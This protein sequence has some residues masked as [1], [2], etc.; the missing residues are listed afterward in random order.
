M[1]VQR[2]G[3]DDPHQIGRYRIL[4]VLGAGGMGRVLLGAGAD[5]RLVAIKQVHGHLLGETEYRARFRREVTATTRVSGAFTAPVIDFDIDAPDPWLASAFV[6]GVPLDQV[7]SEWGPLPV[8]ALRMLAAGLA[9]AL[10]AV[11]RAG[12]VHRDL[13]PA[14]VLLAADGPRVIDFGIAQLAENPGGLTE[15]GSAL[16]SPAFMSPEQALSERVSSASDVFSL[17]V[18]L[19][20]AATGT[21]PFAAQ[22]MAYTLFNIVH[23][24]PDLSRVPP[25]FRELL[26]AC[27]D[28]DPAAR[29]T[30]AQILR[31]LGR[32]ESFGRP[33]PE[34]IHQEIDRRASKLTVLTADPEGTSVLPGARRNPATRTAMAGAPSAHRRGRSRILVTA[35]VALLV[36]A[37]TAGAAWWRW[38]GE[39]ATDPA[40][41][42]L[43]ELR[44]TDACGWLRAALGS[45][46]P[47]NLVPAWSPDV[48]TWQFQTEPD[49]SCRAVGGRD[50]TLSFQPGGY[51]DALTRTGTTLA[52]RPVL[53]S[54]YES[55]CERGLQ[56]AG[57]Q[58]HWGL[59]VS[60]G[61]GDQCA[62]ADY[63]LAKSIA[64]GSPPRAADRTG[65]LA[66]VDPC[67]LVDR[68]TLTAMLGPQP[69]DNAKGA[70][71]VCQWTGT[72]D[73]KVTASR[74]RTTSRQYPEVDLGDGRVLLAPASTV[75]SICTR[76]FRYR[77]L[78]EFT[79]QLEIRIQG[80][81]DNE[82]N[83]R[84]AESIARVVVAKLP[85]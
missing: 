14:N 73:L 62:L 46:L 6:L 59:R 13:K 20:N 24:D 36:V 26:T 85:K 1:T 12:L 80:G 21:H 77:E 35:L 7:I 71:H 45:T 66:L 47:E 4:G 57:A 56:T 15:T 76:D 22:T 5:G 40:R 54:S 48:T 74:E 75:A 2:P 42:T 69:D 51:F 41:H 18:L 10:E 32:P 70:A 43:A 16:G 23:V 25:E 50:R 81:S 79:E 52:G 9:A 68:E 60:V 28:K 39:K 27:L 29:P 8:P 30:P 37:I 11:H 78:G 19:M 34:P 83:C 84:T 53:G 64:I 3:P 61:K 49:W 63:T 72:Q 17:G 65:S 55:S 82:A 33:W 31:Y 38:D 44:A 67:T 58:E